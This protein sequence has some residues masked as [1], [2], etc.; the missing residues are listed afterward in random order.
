MFT[1]IARSYAAVTGISGCFGA[2]SVSEGSAIATA[3]VCA[4]FTGI[5]MSFRARS[6]S[7]GPGIAL[8]N[9]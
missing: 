6:V 5:V 3:R 2:P 1:G 8:L 4:M 7:E 9:R